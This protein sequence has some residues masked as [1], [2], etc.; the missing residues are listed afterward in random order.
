M[1]RFT[2]RGLTPQLFVV[3]ILPLIGLLL[4]IAF[5]GLYLHRQAMR[6]LVGE[7]DERAARAAASA[8][9]EQFNH[10]AAAVQ[11]LALRVEPETSSNTLAEILKESE[12]LLPDFDAGLAFLTTNGEPLAFIGE[13]EVWEKLIPSSLP[14]LGSF[15]VR[16]SSSFFSVPNPSSGELTMIAVASIPQS[17]LIAA[18]AFSP[19]I[20]ARNALSNVFAP[21]SGAVAFLVDEQFRLLFT[22]GPF[23]KE[24]D[25]RSH[26]GVDRALAGESGTTFQQISGEEHVI[27]FSPVSPVGWALIIDEPWEVVTSPLLTTTE[28]APLALIPVLLLAVVA[29]WF[30]T[31]RIV[32]P[33][34]ELESKAAGLGWGD[35]ETIEEPVG[36][37]A[38]IRRLQSELVHMAHKVRT[39]QQALRSYIGAITAGQEEE[40]RR[41]ARELHDDTLQS[42]IALNQRVQLVHLSLNGKPEAETMAEIQKLTEETIQNLRRVTRALRPIYLEDLGLVAALDMLV[43]EIQRASNVT[44]DFQKTG[45]ERRLPETVELALFRI[46]QETLSNIVRHAQASQASV[47][48]NY[49]QE[50]VRLEVVDNGRGFEVPESPAEFAPSGHFGLLGMHERAELVGARLKIS[51]A[52]G[53]RTSVLVELPNEIS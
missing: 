19:T 15:S 14:E 8:L 51:S 36:G 12:F 28:Y 21:G 52:P 44:F 16:E 24:I 6:N 9:R 42:L 32:Q 26:P 2:W 17:P 31:D 37:I 27:A 13:S 53:E 7:R 10:R 4:L 23:P 20:I 47:R 22:M 38:E 5:G 41:L 43:Q 29:L 46:A 50:S 48:L 30:G 34:Q 18:G 40:R 33:L 1:P 39:A 35:F 11:G 49:G 25:L 45:P 3:V